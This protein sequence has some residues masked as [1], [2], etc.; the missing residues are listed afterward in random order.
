MSFRQ[1]LRRYC[2]TLSLVGFVLLFCGVGLVTILRSA[3]VRGWVTASGS[4]IVILLYGLAIDRERAQEDAS[5]PVPLARPSNALFM[6]GLGWAVTIYATLMVLVS[7]LTA[8]SWHLD[9]TEPLNVSATYAAKMLAGS[10]L[11]FLLGAACLWHSTLNRRAIQALREN[12][13]R[14]AIK[15]LDEMRSTPDF[16]RSYPYGVRLRLTNEYECSA[17]EL[18]KR[19]AQCTRL[20]DGTYRLKDEFREGAAT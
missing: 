11:F 1:T 16:T 5:F 7:W 8:A 14:L 2:G 17:D 12:E 9:G 20:S 18:L 15:L 6:R 10:A 13:K 19:L 3:G 4:F